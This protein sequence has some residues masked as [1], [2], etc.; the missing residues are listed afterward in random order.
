MVKIK[1]SPEDF[2]VEEIINLKTQ[3]TGDHTYFWL[4]KKN[5]TTVRAIREIA[6]RY[7]VSFRRF[8]FAGTKDANAITRQAV[9][10]FQVEPK[11]LERIKIKDIRVE[12]IGKGDRQISLGD[13]TA[14]KFK[15]VI[16][17]LTKED[18]KKLE[19]N[20][21]KIKEGFLNYFGEQR[22]GGGNT[23]LVGREIIK[24]NLEKA[25]KYV[26]TFSEVRNKKAAKF[27]NFAQKN[28]KKWKNILAKTPKFLGLEK[29]VLNLLV[30][31][32]NDFAGALRTLPKPIRR[33]YV[34][35]YQSWIWNQVLE[36]AKVKT[37][38]RL[39]IPGFKTKLGK[40]KFSD[41]IKK[42]LKKDKIKLE[43]FV[44][45]RMPELASEGHFRDVIVVPKNFKV[46]EPK[47]DELNKN[48]RAVELEFELPKG[49]YATT[50]LK[51][52]FDGGRQKTKASLHL[53]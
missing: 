28:W 42:I 31:Y 46:G 11:T 18:L 10:A 19:G 22:F 5:W 49:A 21:Y 53:S 20:K 3:K 51:E 52:L 47:A 25:I 35:A 1:Q 34:H 38:K 36:K 41:N 24:G 32:P 43:D 27:R 6:R 40:D 9:S 14:N 15:V 37:N 12:V 44:C 45:A 23:H 7:G 4:T 8:R 13:L 30:R 33:M 29:S 16:R 48:R 17:A 50:L 2:M 39:P 26:L